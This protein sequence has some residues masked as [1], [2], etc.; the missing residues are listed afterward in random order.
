MNI[1]EN[2]IGIDYHS[3]S[4]QISV[5]AG[6]TG[7]K[8][9][10]RRFANDVMEV[11][12]YAK[13]F[14][15]VSG[16]AIEACTGSANFA[17]ELRQVS[18]WG[19]RLCHPGYVQRM[20]HNPDKSD[21]SDGD[22]LGDLN[23]VGYLPEV[24]LAPQRLRDLRTLLRFRASL[25]NEQRSQKLRVRALLR[26]E[27]VN[28]PADYKD[29]W[30]VKGLAWLRTVKSF[31]M[32]T[33][34]VFEQRLEQIEKVSK[35]INT[36]DKRLGKELKG[37]RLVARLMQ[38]PGIGLIT[39]ALLRAEIGTFS[40]FRTGKQLSR[41]CGMTPRNCSS[42]ERQIDA[43]LIKAGNPLLRA[44]LIQAGHN[45]CRFSPNWRGLAQRLLTAGKPVC[46]V[47][48][49][50]VNRWLRKLYHEMVE[51]ERSEKLAA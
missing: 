37:D 33:Q 19:V 48:A 27:R 2:S 47:I 21:K 43:G 1:A 22:L 51:F 35:E 17:Q 7:A 41:F 31:P 44:A 23:R 24:W 16:C 5:I 45:I 36:C 49:A 42:G 46:V 38:E 13:R 29:I 14:G 28:I 15:G 34:G 20:R 12:G 4:V 26:Q 9:G 40:R 25:V 18:G 6:S 39:A 50:V 32:Q 30:S 3:K 11:V 10:S 8:L